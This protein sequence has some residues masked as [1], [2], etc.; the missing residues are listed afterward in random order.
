[1]VAI[2]KL[3]PENIEELESRFRN[4][5][6]ILE[7]I[8]GIMAESTYHE[9]RKNNVEFAARME[10]AKDYITEIA[11]GVVAKKVKL[12]DTETAK[13]WLERRNKK[14]FSSRT[15]LTGEDGKDL[16]T[17]IL[18]GLTKKDEVPTNDSTQ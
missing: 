1:M 15:E 17:P 9:N 2:S 3:T 18:G 10:L 8:D 13:W 4:G 12:G 7:A 6:T 14:Q 16:P 5:A 11:R